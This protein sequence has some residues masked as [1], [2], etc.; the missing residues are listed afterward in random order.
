LKAT[1]EKIEL[2]DRRAVAVLY[3][4]GGLQHRAEAQNIVLSAGVI[5]SPKLLMLSGIGDGEELRRHRIE[6][7]IDLPAVGR[8]LK[9]HPLLGMNYRLR[10]PTYNLTEG[11]LQKLA[12]AGK[13][14]RFREGPI[15]A[16]YES[17]ALLKTESL[18]AGPTVQIFFAPIG[19]QKEA[20][21]SLSL[22][23]FP[24]AKVVILRSHSAS[25]G[26]VRLA[27]SDPLALPL[28]E[29]RLLDHPS[30]IDVLVDATTR[31]RQIMNT[32]PMANLIEAETMPGPDEGNVEAVRE[33][34][35]SHASMACH[36]IG[37]CRM[38]AGED[39][40]V[41]P[42]LRVRG[43]ENLWIADASVFPDP[44]SANL[45]AV[46]MM[47]GSKLGKQLAVA[48]PARS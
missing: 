11:F 40:V 45:N 22:S 46:C 23:P 18:S 25:S 7:M 47:I 3:R 17:V 34:V 48:G 38:A 43:T 32:A 27:S 15:A 5:N 42:D 12:I 24:A 4:R 44:I 1:V 20:D 9:E 26:R 39:A 33:Y 41:G 35:R 16:A 14:A 36:P 6:V 10:V 30:D 8:H 28:I 19:F 37:T 31:V 21:G 13:Y 29:H 2:R